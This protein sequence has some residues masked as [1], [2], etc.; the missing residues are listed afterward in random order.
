MTE[1]K[2]VVSESKRKELEK[3]L[4]QLTKTRGYGKNLLD[5]LWQ[6]KQPVQ[7]IPQTG[8]VISEGWVCVDHEYGHDIVA[9]GEDNFETC[10]QIEYLIKQIKKYSG[11][12]VKLIL[13]V[14]DE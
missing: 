11:K 4:D 5:E 14:C 9:I 12:K 10:S 7:D 6:S 13:E 2:Y 8:K 3:I 1:K